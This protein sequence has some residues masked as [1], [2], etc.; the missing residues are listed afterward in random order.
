M[1]SWTIRDHVGAPIDV[2]SP[3]YILS[4]YKL[5]KIHDVFN[6]RCLSKFVTLVKDI[7]SEWWKDL[8]KF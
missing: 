1:E 4:Y 6:T 5:P 2:I 8:S 7:L 3:A